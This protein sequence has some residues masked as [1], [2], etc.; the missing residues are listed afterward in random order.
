MPVVFTK[1]IRVFI[2]ALKVQRVAM[3]DEMGS[4]TIRACLADLQ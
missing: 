1:S 2:V 4:E 3:I